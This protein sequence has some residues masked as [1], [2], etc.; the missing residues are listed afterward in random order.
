[1]AIDIGIDRKGH[2]L[3]MLVSQALEH[4]PTA[5]LL[6]FL[7]DRNTIVRT[8]AACKLQIRGEPEVFAYAIELASSRL[9][10]DREIAAFLMGQIGT[11][12]YPF[13]E[14]SVTRLVKL[15]TDT[16]HEVRIAA[17]AG[18]GHLRAVDA[19]EVVRA[20]RRDVHPDVREMANY[21]YKQIT[22]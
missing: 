15:C 13:K 18:L 6:S 14:A 22:G 20:A 5:S 11:P 7:H 4:Y 9:K 3:R 17:L 16:S 1:M 2:S 12:T 10:T 21:V 8:A 19:I